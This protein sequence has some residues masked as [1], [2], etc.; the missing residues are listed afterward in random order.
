[1]SENVVSYTPPPT[2]DG[3]IQHYLP[4]KL[5]FDWAVGPVGSGKT[6]GIFFKL[7]YMMQQQAPSP[8]DG[9]RRT[10]AVVVRNTN[11]QL[12][13]TTLTSWSYWFKDKVAGTWVASDSKFILRFA[14]CECEVLFR[15]LDNPDDVQRVLS[16]EVTF[17]IV[18]EFV[19]IGHEII[20]SLSARC[21]RYPPKIDG[22]ATNWGMW[23]STN[24]GN[25]DDWWYPYLYEDKPVNVELFVQPDGLS[26]DAENTDNLPGG[27]D[28][29]T[30][31]IQGKTEA[32][33]N[34]YVR[35]NWGHSLVGTPVISTFRREFHVAKY[36]LM[37]DPLRPL[38][39]GFDPGMASGLVFGQFTSDDRLRVLAESVQFGY[40]A[41][42]LIKEKL[43][44]ILRDQFAGATVIISPDPAA[45]NRAQTDERSVVDVFKAAGFNVQ[46]PDMNNRIQPRLEAIEHYTTRLTADGPALEVDP[47][48]KRLIRALSGGWCYTVSK[49][50]HTSVEPE[51]NKHS[52][53]GDAY[54]YLCRFGHK[55]TGKMDRDAVVAKAIAAQRVSTSY[56]CR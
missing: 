16:L 18:D 52:H 13:D 47:S 3:F 45:F 17:A 23:G 53:I 36:P 7:V 46:V 27:R 26:P 48:C 28:Y 30:S 20:E 11:Q 14:D 32:W 50:E 31:L 56:N 22:G 49:K 44:P 51:K 9:I 8:I 5:F 24:P 41:S 33:I 42:R 6:T 54:S 19:Q 34:Q 25:E 21:G 2:M 37:Y 15:P 43:Q 1:M 35:V 10:R 55:M 39:V 29:Y 40:G 4:G 38:I 12:R